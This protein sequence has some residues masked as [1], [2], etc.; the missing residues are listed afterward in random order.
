MNEASLMLAF[1]CPNCWNEIAAGDTECAHCSYLVEEDNARSYEAKL[2]R[3]L[4]HPVRENR[5]MA[6]QLLG[7]LR[8]TSALPVFASLLEEE[9]DF[10]VIR[11][12]AQALGRIGT[13]ERRGMLRDLEH[14]RS[15]L[16]RRLALGLRDEVS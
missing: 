9:V 3:A 16:V 15:S 13:R 6:I 7:E 5:M 10:H 2:I 12:I 14:H 4:T 8:S 11:E 1:Y